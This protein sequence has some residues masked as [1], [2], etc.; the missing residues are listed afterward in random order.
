MKTRLLVL[1]VCCVLS[2]NATFQNKQN[3]VDQKPDFKDVISSLFELK[4]TFLG[5]SKNQA[6]KKLDHVSGAFGSIG[7]LLGGLGGGGGSAGGSESSGGD[8][9]S[10][11]S[12]VSSGSNGYSYQ[13]PPPPPQT[14]YLPPP[15]Q[16]VQSVENTYLPPQM[17][18]P[19]PQPL[20]PNGGYQYQQPSGGISGSEYSS[21]GTAFA[22]DDKDELSLPAN[23]GAKRGGGGHGLLSLLGGLGGGGS[24]GGIGGIFSTIG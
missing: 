4:K 16:H 21:D 11:G 5:A 14:S 18:I 6:N 20:A 24:G 1:L 3:E 15:V 7:G 9:S 19:P 12:E 2:V 13:P 17:Y 23:D 10:S 8:F 22:S